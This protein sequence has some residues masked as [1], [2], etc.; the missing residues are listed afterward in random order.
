MSIKG[1]GKEDPQTCEVQVGRTIT[2]RIQRFDPDVDDVPRFQDLTMATAQGTTILGALIELHEKVDPSLA[3]SYACRS[4]VC[5]SCAMFIQGKV[6]L[7][8]ETQVLDVERKGTVMISPLPHQTVVRDLVIDPTHFFER[9]ERSMPYLIG[10]EGESKGDA[11]ESKGDAGESKGDAGESKGDAGATTDPAVGV[12]DEGEGDVYQDHPP[13]PVPDEVAVARE[14]LQTIEERD[15]L[16]PFTDCILCGGC[17]A[18]CTVAWT[19]DD[20]LGPAALMRVYRF[21]LD[22]RDTAL[23]E[24]LDLVSTE[25]G[26]WRCHTIFNCSENCPKGLDPAVA[27]QGLKKLVL[28]R[29]FSRNK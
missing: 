28:K 2:Y 3:L 17:T 19:N 1:S 26:L 8:C 11:G 4:A 21:V 18:S 13:A 16:E 6:R 24:R 25:V 15:R 5:G 27:I 20:Y 12:E 10:G 22:S 9:M 23:D 14:F 29:K 7:A